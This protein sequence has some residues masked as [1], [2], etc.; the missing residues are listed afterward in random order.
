MA[1]STSNACRFLLC[2]SP[3]DALVKKPKAP[4]IIKKTSMKPGMLP[5]KNVIDMLPKINT[6]GA[7]KAVIQRLDLLIEAD[8]KMNSKFILKIP[9]WDLEDE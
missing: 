7:M 1:R 5:P 2:K 4:R 6:T 3:I 9:L 8:E